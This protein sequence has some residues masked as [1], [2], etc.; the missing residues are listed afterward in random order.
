M[1][2][3]YPGRFIDLLGGVGD[4]LVLDCGSGGRPDFVDWPNIVLCEYVEH[5]LNTVRGDALALPFSDDTFDLVLSQATLEHVTDP[6]QAVDEMTRVLRPGGKL[7]IEV[8]FMQPLHQDPWH[9][10]NVTP[11]G[12]DHLCRHL[13][14]IEKGAFGTLADQFE[15]M[16]RE[17]G[18]TD[19][20]AQRIVHLAGRLDERGIDA[21]HLRRVASAVS[22]LA[23]KRERGDG[24]APGPS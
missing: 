12:L 16:L 21:E 14:V 4:G 23:A 3:P 18:E 9:Y 11:H 1:T 13:D 5:P 7:Y 8:A 10:F 20:I 2:N 19:A 24:A 6:Q 15:W 17:A 22:V